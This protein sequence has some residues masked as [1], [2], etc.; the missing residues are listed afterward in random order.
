MLE[1]KYVS[2]SKTRKNKRPYRLSTENKVINVHAFIRRGE[3]D[4]MVREY[5][6]LKL[7]DNL[8]GSYSSV[9]KIMGEAMILGF[10]L[11]KKNKNKS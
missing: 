8:D 3:Y 11:I 5:D 2:Y 4:R 1:D 6:D 10:E 7:G 9:G